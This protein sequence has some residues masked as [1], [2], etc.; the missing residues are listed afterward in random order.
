MNDSKHIA[1][2]RARQIFHC[3]IDDREYMAVKWPRQIRQDLHEPYMANRSKPPFA[4]AVHNLDALVPFDE[5]DDY[6]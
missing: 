6:L 5:L 3:Q 2:N 1:I 4:V